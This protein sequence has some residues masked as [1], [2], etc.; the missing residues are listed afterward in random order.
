MEVTRLAIP[1]ILLVS[2]DVYAD[3]RGFLTESWNIER[4]MEAG[5]PEVEFKQDNF[6]YSKR[7]V[8]RG[9]HFQY[10]CPQGKL[11]QVLRGEVFDVAIDI[12][13]GSP[14]Y[15]KW[16]G[17]TL[18]AENHQQLWIPPG[19]AHGFCVLSDEVEFFYKCTEVYKP[20]FDTG[21]R[22]DDPDIAIDWPIE[23]PI[24]SDKDK[25]LPLLAELHTDKLAVY[26][27]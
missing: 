2:T 17:L 26:D 9:L 23:Q 4:Y 20:E 18:S 25:A 13:Y 21:I 3:K 22:W 8:L 12:R 5:F 1:D 27:K 19:F 15:L 14:H 7:D 6:S 10:P 24:V 11:V 16:V